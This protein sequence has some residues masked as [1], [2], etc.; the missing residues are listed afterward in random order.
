[1]NLA[2]L[3]TGFLLSMGRLGSPLGGRNREEALKP[4]VEGKRPEAF[5]AAQVLN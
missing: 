4:S 1:M 5:L 3:F 2:G